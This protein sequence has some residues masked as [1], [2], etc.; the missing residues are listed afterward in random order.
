M[1]LLSNAIINTYSIIIL[2]IVYH[3]S[4]KHS[5]KDSFQHK[6]FTRMILITLL[7]LSADTFSRFDGKPDTIYSVLNYFGNMS[8]FLVSPIFP[9]IWLQYAHY[10]VFQEE[11]RSKKL[12][13]PLLIIHCINIIMLIFTQYFGWYYYIDSANIYH[14]GPFFLF[15]GLLAFS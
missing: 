14:R 9:S 8:I 10:Q 12:I 11:T 15:S 3:Q 1:N 2:I 6:L 5:E 4:T 7:M 13:Y